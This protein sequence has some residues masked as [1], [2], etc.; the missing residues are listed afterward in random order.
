MID[1]INVCE[2]CEKIEKGKVHIC[3]V[4]NFVEALKNVQALETQC[5]KV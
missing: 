3:I 2:N 1:E 4:Q 5:V